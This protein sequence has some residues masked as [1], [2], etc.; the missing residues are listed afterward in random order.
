[1]R[2]NF[3]KVKFKPVIVGG[4]FWDQDITDELGYQNHK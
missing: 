2:D 1:M 3:T 4:V